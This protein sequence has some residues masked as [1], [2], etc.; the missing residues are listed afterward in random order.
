VCFGRC[1]FTCRRGGRKVG[2][3][4]ER[5]FIPMDEAQQLNEY[6]G[7]QMTD[8]TGI[9]KALV[10]AQAEMTKPKKDALNPHFKSKYADLASVCDACLPA[11]NKHGI[12]VIQPLV[13]TEAGLA[14]KTVFVH[15]ESG[16]DISTEI[17]LMVPQAI[18]MQQLGSAMTYARRYGLLTLSGIAPD[19]DDGQSA[20]SAGP[21]K[22]KQDPQVITKATKAALL[23]AC[24]DHEGF[25][26]EA[27]FTDWLFRLCKCDVG[28]LSDA[29][30]KKILAYISANPNWEQ[31]DDE[32]KRIALVEATTEWMAA[33]NVDTEPEGKE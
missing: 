25:P 22:V 11:L 18:Q 14:V 26:S 9:Y 10:L 33:Q 5:K 6:L 28:Q 13:R 4:T 32:R 23:Q 21:A 16:E 27:V 12:A 20:A 29:Q 24:D 15:S 8:K 1:V 30:G 2:A 7:E 3:M 17:P 19:D 31:W